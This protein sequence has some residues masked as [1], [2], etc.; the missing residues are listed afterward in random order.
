[1]KSCPLVV[2]SLLLCLFTLPT[3][4]QIQCGTDDIYKNNPALQQKVQEQIKRLQ[5]A[6]NLV[7]PNTVF[8]IPVVFII[9]HKGEAEGAGSNLSDATILQ[10]LNAL[11]DAF[12]A[13][14]GYAA[15]NDMKIEFALANCGDMN[16]IV[17]VDASEVPNYSDN[18][19]NYNDLIM[20][21]QLRT[22]HNWSDRDNYITIELVHKI[23]GAGGFAGYL[24]GYTF[25]DARLFGIGIMAHELGHVLNLKHTFEGDNFGFQCPPNNDPEND[26]DMISD[27]PPHKRGQ[28]CYNTPP[29]SINPCDSL[30][31]GDIFENFLSYSEYCWRKF[32]PKQI[33]RARNSVAQFK[34]NWFN[35]P[36][37]SAQTAAPAAVSNLRCGTGTVALTA[38]GCLGTY[39]W[40]SQSTGGEALATGES[41]TTPPIETTT[42]Y[43]VDCQVA[44]CQPS[45]RVAVQAIVT[46]V[47]ECYCESYAM[48]L[49][50][51]EIYNFSFTTINTSSN[52]NT[53]GGPGSV[54]SAYSNYTF[55]TPA[56]AYT[57]K[58][59]PFSVQIGSCGGSYSNATKI[60]IDFN[61]DKD[62]ND[63]GEEVYVSPG[64]TQGA[65]VES[66][67]I[68]I[69]ADALA[70]ITRIRIVTAEASPSSIT[71]CGAY[72]F[73]ETEDY[74]LNII[75]CPDNLSYETINQGMGTYEAA[76]SISS[77][78]NVST[79]VTYL[80]GQ[81]I[82]L[83]PGFS[84]GP[85]EVFTSTIGGCY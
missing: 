45:V 25:I 76:I 27:T 62:F 83:L 66:D 22:L 30:T 43:Y 85:N 28:N 67:T 26:G 33:E 35:S 2:I 74:A 47:N 16:S 56:I 53:T 69:P 46:P 20:I 78:A 61:H 71:P 38:S 41:F 72:G 23:N 8:T 50:D 24:E 79:P 39:S 10:Q 48:Y 5:N 31:Y 15:H 44:T 60:Y 68:T 4:S 17:R 34:P 73:G 36:Y 11:N 58:S 14:N 54:R 7:D 18:G 84:A 63:A 40:Y 49:G 3:F 81:Y 51:E 59:Y 64:T 1:M 80:A 57:G 55:D 13:R 82:V 9:Y 21:F 70:G 37:L 52:C 32:T 42:T 77:K 29:M 6:G 12:R 19:L 65:H 75:A